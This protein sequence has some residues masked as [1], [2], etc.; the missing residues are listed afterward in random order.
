[1]TLYYSEPQTAEEVFARARAVLAR[2]ATWGTR[3]NL[4]DEAR[5]N[6]I[7]ASM[8]ARESAEEAKRRKQEAKRRKEEARVVHLI[9]VRKAYLDDPR[10][11]TERI[12]AEVA[13]RFGFS[14]S[15]LVG[16]SR[17]RD[18][19][20]ARQSAIYLARELALALEIRKVGVRQGLV[21]LGRRFGNRDHT[22]ALHA[23]RKIAELI[24]IDP[25]L[26]E[27]ISDVREELTGWR[28]PQP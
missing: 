28:E 1:M 19:V 9:Q 16:S 24:P 6:A 3:Q 27:K 20:R 21:G 14:V 4:L 5:R 18:I 12:K 23:I 10:I 11:S 22:T 13:K 15:A 25:D 26:A 8:R 17:F 7:I 2:R